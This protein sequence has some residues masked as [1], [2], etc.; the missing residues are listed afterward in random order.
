MSWS[1][2]RSRLAIGKGWKFMLRALRFAR[3]NVN[4]VRKRGRDVSD[5]SFQNLLVAWEELLSEG[6][7]VFGETL[8]VVR[9]REIVELF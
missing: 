6:S 2:K 7:T 1:W 9:D 4:Q 8:F 5:V 3:Y